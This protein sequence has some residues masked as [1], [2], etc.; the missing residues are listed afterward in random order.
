MASIWSLGLEVFIE[1]AEIGLERWFSKNICYKC[2]TYVPISLLSFKA[3]TGGANTYYP[4]NMGCGGRRI[5]GA[6]WL[7]G[8]AP[9]SVRDSVSRSYGE[10]ALSYLWSLLTCTR[11]GTGSTHTFA[12]STH[13]HNTLTGNK[14]D[15]RNW[16][17]KDESGEFCVV[18][19]VS[20]LL[21]VGYQHL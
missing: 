6:G 10:D 20:W 4:S 15:L 18:S 2:G 21:I 19:T 9:G 5:T 16:R 1:T 12:G 7:A 3:G 8:L 11:M 14:N 13:A 17:C